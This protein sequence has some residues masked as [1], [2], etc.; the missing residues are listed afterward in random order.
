MCLKAPPAGWKSSSPPTAAEDDGDA[1]YLLGRA[2]FDAREYLRCHHALRDAVEPRSRF[3]CTYAL[4]LAGETRRQEDAALA[5]PGGAPKKE[6]AAGSAGGAAAAPPSN[7][8]LAEVCARVEQQAGC[9]FSCY[10]LGVC[11]RVMGMEEQALLSLARAVQLEPFLWAAW[12]ELA[13]L[14]CAERYADAKQGPGVDMRITALGLGR[15]WMFRMFVAHLKCELQSY[16][17]SLAAADSVLVACPGSV[18][19]RTLRALT[20]YNMR[21]FEGAAALFEGM[22]RD[23]PYRI[24]DMDVY[25]NVL[26]VRGERAKLSYLAHR[27]AKTD[28]Y[29]PE[30]CCIIGNYYSMRGS[31]LKVML[32]SRPS[33]LPL[34]LCLH[35][36]SKK[37]VSYFQRALRLNPSYLSAWTLMGHE[38]M[39]LSNS[40]AAINCYRRAVDINDRDF[41]A[42]YALGQAYEILA[43]DSYALWYFHKACA[44]RP[45]D[46]RMWVALGGCFEKTG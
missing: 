25:S 5:V 6:E 8:F 36:L 24:A 1:V 31:H 38:Y 11:Q 42:W 18:F 27:V 37:A 12:W 4:Y 33:P 17:D 29:R 15:H 35:T 22:W 40:V 34:F 3:L 41:R 44:L 21:E 7:P 2:Y 30:S 26:Y 9:G 28:R 43:M 45:G 13:R 10:L 23:E 19:G 32:Y 39:E 46:A 20:L 16:E 14:L